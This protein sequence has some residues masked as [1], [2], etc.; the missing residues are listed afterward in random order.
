MFKFEEFENFLINCLIIYYKVKN[1]L[2][3]KV[4]LYLLFDLHLYIILPNNK[5]KYAF[6]F[7]FSNIFISVIL[8]I[9]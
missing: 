6:K 3:L 4:N 7:S 8:I 1:V 2:L 5:L 9:I